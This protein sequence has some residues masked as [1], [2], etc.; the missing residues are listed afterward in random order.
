MEGQT[1]VKQWFNRCLSVFPLGFQAVVYQMYSSAKAQLQEKG[2]VWIFAWAVV[3]AQITIASIPLLVDYDASTLLITI[4]GTVFAMLH[5]SF[6]RWEE[7]KWCCRPNTDQTYS[8]LEGNGGGH[9]MVVFGNKAEKKIAGLG[10][11]LRPI[12]LP[13][14]PTAADDEAFEAAEAKWADK[15]GGGAG[16]GTAGVGGGNTGLVRRR[17]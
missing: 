3:E 1:F 5:W 14:K 17:T 2:W 16:Q 10:S 13:V 6:Q 11:I 12:Y 15:A 7:E 8:L 9:V 4:L